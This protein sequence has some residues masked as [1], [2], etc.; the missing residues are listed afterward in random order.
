MRHLFILLRIYLVALALTL[1]GAYID[2]DTPNPS[3][4]AF[5]FEILAMSV[6]VFGLLT[7]IFYSLFFVFKILKQAI[8]RYFN[9]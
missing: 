6:V 3:K 7:G 4:V 5:G 8:E 2:S 9:S 1:F